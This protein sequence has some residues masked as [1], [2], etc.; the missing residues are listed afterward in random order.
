MLCFRPS[1]K[2]L[3][4][5]IYFSLASHNS[6]YVFRTNRDIHTQEE[7]IKKG[8]KKKEKITFVEHLLCTRN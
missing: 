6:F 7:K 4:E 8:R 2:L 5:Q 1:A 3:L